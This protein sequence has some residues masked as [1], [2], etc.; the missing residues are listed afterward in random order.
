[1][2]AWTYYT[3]TIRLCKHCKERVHEYSQLPGFHHVNENYRCSIKDICCI[4]ESMTLP[5][6]DLPLDT[7]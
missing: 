2:T 1:M 6:E 7:S 5:D 4:A 3:K